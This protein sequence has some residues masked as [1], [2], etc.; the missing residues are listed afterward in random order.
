MKLSSD[1]CMLFN[2]SFVEYF[3]SWLIVILVQ[4]I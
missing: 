3:L 2:V 1:V 4:H